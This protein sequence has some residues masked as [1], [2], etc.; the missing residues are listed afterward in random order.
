MILLYGAGSKDDGAGL[1]GKAQD[2]FPRNTMSSG[3]VNI[4]SVQ[5]AAFN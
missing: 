3:L 5:R 4:V 2:L 1:D